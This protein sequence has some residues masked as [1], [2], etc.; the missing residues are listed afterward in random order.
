M[1]TLCAGSW[2][3]CAVAWLAVG[4][5]T[6][7]VGRNRMDDREAR[8]APVLPHEPTGAEVNAT[9]G[10]KEPGPCQLAGSMV[11]IRSCYSKTG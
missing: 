5:L 1:A 6:N 3:S 2:A 10:Q 8:T 7:R 4:G 11:E 9:T